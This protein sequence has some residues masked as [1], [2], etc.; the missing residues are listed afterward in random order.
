MK[1]A[2]SSLRRGKMSS[3]FSLRGHDLMI[4]KP[5]PFFHNHLPL[6]F[7]KDY[8][9]DLFDIS[10]KIF[11]FPYLTACHFSFLVYFIFHSDVRNFI[12]N[13]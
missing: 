1:L 8:T 12:L 9:I 7:P 13:T 5:L 4:R 3:R 2:R 11:A 6:K 10:E